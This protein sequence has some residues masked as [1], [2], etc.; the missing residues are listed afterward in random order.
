MEKYPL[1]DADDARARLNAVVNT[2]EEIFDNVTKHAYAELS[3]KGAIDVIEKLSAAFTPLREN[4]FLACDS[5]KK[6]L[7][8]PNAITVLN[9]FQRPID[10]NID[11]PVK[12]DFPL[13]LNPN[14]QFGYNKE[15]E[16]FRKSIQ[17]QI[18]LAGADVNNVPKM[19]NM[20]NRI[21]EHCYDNKVYKI[22]MSEDNPMFQYLRRSLISYGI[23]MNNERIGITG[24]KSVYSA[25]YPFTK[26]CLVELLVAERTKARYKFPEL[27][28]VY[29]IPS[30]IA[31][32]Y[33]YT[34][35]NHDASPEALTK[36][37]D[38]VVEILKK[39][40]FEMPIALQIRESERRMDEAAKSGN[41]E[42][43]IK[44]QDFRR[45]VEQNA[46]KISRP[47]RG[48]R[49][50]TTRSDGRT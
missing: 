47:N 15:D 38:K 28:S 35:A 22:Y 33:I 12:Q 6:Q 7:M 16:A 29:N 43:I 18:D 3:I 44:A 8:G 26:E 49:Q 40:E 10:C 17:R 24:Y 2:P 14:P 1:R 36:A 34:I 19:I 27:T 48:Q 23:T 37:Y 31:S 5:M 50:T 45:T 30:D 25:N 42:Q 21:A 39:Y 41:V 4:V 46:V 13:D 20:A 11:I 32:E 9:H